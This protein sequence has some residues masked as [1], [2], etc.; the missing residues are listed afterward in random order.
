MRKVLIF[1]VGFVIYGVGVGVPSRSSPTP[2]PSNARSF[3][4]T[5]RVAFV[6]N[7]G[8]GKSTL[9]YAIIGGT[10]FNAGLSHTGG[11]VTTTMN[12]I[13]HPESGIWYVDTPGLD[14]YYTNRQKALAEIVQS[15][16]HNK[17]CSGGLKLVFVIVLQCGRV[18][19][20]DVETITSVL[21]TF[22]EPRLIPYS[23]II[24][25]VTEDAMKLIFSGQCEKDGSCQLTD[26]WKK[27]AHPAPKKY[28]NPCFFIYRMVKERN[29]E[30][31]AIHIPDDKLLFFLSQAP[32]VSSSI[33]VKIVERPN[34][35]DP[36]KE[37]IL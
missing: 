24:N 26:E 10:P 19:Q 12:E 16:K 8:A 21:D 7:P 5:E 31:N 29:G 4:S 1:C 25:K 27:A 3:A 13:Q 17:D 2:Q 9:L 18:S 32:V 15:L 22:P 28:A 11:G 33:S 20:S 14:D 35:D 23:I 37:A 34:Y 30:D 6:G 36:N